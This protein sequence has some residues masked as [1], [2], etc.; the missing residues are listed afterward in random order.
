MCPNPKDILLNQIAL[1]LDTPLPSLNL[2]SSFIENGGDSLSSIQLQAAFRALGVHIGFESIFTSDTISHL[3][4]VTTP[5]LSLALA[6][7]DG[8]NCNHGKKRRL[9]A[10]TEHATKKRRIPTT[11]T[12][13]SV[14]PT[15]RYPMTEMQLA[16]VHSSQSHAG[17]NIIFY[18]ETHHPENVPAI[19]QAWKAVIKAE[20]IFRTTFELHQSGGYMV[21]NAEAD[22]IWEEIFV[23]DEKSFKIQLEDQDIED[24]FFGT[25]FRVITLSSDSHRTGRSTIIWRVHHAL[26]D[27]Y[28]SSL[29]LLK[30]RRVLH[31]EVITP[32]PSFGQFAADLNALQQSREEEGGLFWTKQEEEHPFRASRILLLAPTSTSTHTKDCLGQ[33]EMNVDIDTLTSQGHR[34]G[35]TSA[36]LF[37]AAWALTLA[38]YVDSD[39]VCFGAVLCG[40][41]LPIAGIEAIVGPTINTLPLSIKFDRDE[42]LTDYIHRVFAQMLALTEFQW[43]SPK[44]G[45]SRDFSS[46]LNVQLE[47]PSQDEFNIHPIEQPYSNIRSDVPL[48]VEVGND[49]T[50]RLSYHADIPSHS[51]ME[52]LMK[53]F[54]RALSMIWNTSFTVGICLGYLIDLE[55]RNVLQK[56]GNWLSGTTRIQSIQDDL[57]S[58]FNHAA[59]KNPDTMALQQGST[60]LTYRDLHI[61]SS[62]V[63]TRISQLISPG[64]VVCVHAD[65]SINWI[66]ATYAVLKAGAVYSPFDEELPAAMRDTNFGTTGAKLYLT[67]NT[68]AKSTRPKS[69]E[70]CLSVEELL[71]DT[72]IHFENDDSE[73]WTARP[74]AVAYLC[75][76]SG[77]TGEPKGVM[78]RHRG[79]VAF[80]SELEVRLFAQPGWKIA[81][82]MSPGFD[83]SIHEIFSALSY[84][85]TLI[86][87]DRLNPFS[88]LKHA[89]AAILTPSVA[90]ALDMEEF[91]NLK[92][93]YLVGEAVPQSVCDI[94]A[95]KKTLYNMYGPTEA[96]CGATIKQ[97][98]AGQP[99]TLGVPNI[100]TRIY[101][102]D[103]REEL[104]PSGVIGEIYLAG[105]QV[106]LGYIGRPD[107]T[108]KRFLPDSINPQFGECMYK[109]GD[110]GYWSENGELM[111]FG[112]SDRQ[113]KLRGFRIDLDDLEIR[114]LR[115]SV[116]TTAVA[117]TRKDDYLVAQVQP[118]DLNLTM[119][120]GKLLKV[121]PSYAMPRH[122]S[123]VESFP[124]TTIG[125][126]DYK[127]MAQETYKT[128]SE[129]ASPCAFPAE[130]ELKVALRDVL[131]LPENINI[132][133]DSNFIELGGTSLQQLFLSQRLTRSLKRHVPVRLILESPTLRDLARDL[134]SLDRVDE[135]AYATSLGDHGVS[136]I[137]REWWEKVQVDGNT[138]AF[139][140]NFACRLGDTIDQSRL[141]FAWNRILERHRILSCRYHVSEEHGL[142][143]GYAEQP[144]FIR[145]TWEIDIQE[146]INKP[147]DLHSSDLIRVTLSPIHMVIVISHIICD[148]TTLK[149]LLSEVADTYN[150]KLL[151]PIRKEYSQTQWSLPILPCQ[152]SF[153]SDYLADAPKPMFSVGNNNPRISWTGTSVVCEI[154]TAI[155]HRM[156]QCTAMQK[157]T[158]HQLSLAAVALAL[159]HK[160]AEC[161]ITIG[162]PYLN[163]N[164]EEDLGVVGLFL[165]PLPIRIR[166]PESKDHSL[167]E[168]VKHSSR[169]ALSRAVPWNQLLAHLNIVADFPN[170]PIL[171]AM[172]TFHEHGVQPTLPIPDVEPLY[173]WTQGS[174]FKIMAEFSARSMSKLL[175][176]LEY[177]TE[178]FTKDD[179]QSMQRMVIAALDGLTAG[180]MYDEIR[181][182]ISS[183]RSLLGVTAP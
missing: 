57:V 181:E 55:H 13:P 160:E 89:D 139:N 161:D 104:V 175:L 53:T 72:H 149:T 2:H 15:I 11:P 93:V 26:I 101:I 35:V 108:A 92:T 113:I 128:Y 41:A 29:V 52:S 154:P 111:F 65:R 138:S 44:H 58:L 166:Y 172:V 78:C 88:H 84:G 28:S 156:Q 21:E 91:P 165:E 14:N 63:S 33:V 19:K 106:S 158:M 94:W 164:S 140:V 67:G 36:T 66:I 147:F 141:I 74:E 127:K 112:R 5:K 131:D 118:A 40:R 68:M 77:S 134:A 121:I 174:K 150:G 80:Q 51:H 59:R 70:I 170:H 137:E 155:Y 122:I 64:D 125:K 8:K 61:K 103:N 37:Y 24:N 60:A 116:Q 6:A 129:A 120:R 178:C 123:A 99:V 81:Q 38:K 109:T 135:T 95:A 148:L 18:H 96:T 86:L 43:S 159:Q 115:A 162:A 144:P 142:S 79:L 100:S 27:G 124:V 45:F 42:R 132:D 179:V 183:T 75:F 119:Y 107:E 54:S 39:D 9:A 1:A 71:L 62:L 73:E 105:V 97:L 50:I 46:A 157:I 34:I 47:F 4:D 171:D 169:A 90:N 10:I 117:V 31:G 136:P 69:C 16:F 87:K 167:L 3:L 85:A 23:H 153:W 163:R 30:M 98:H 83:G 76:T 17:R 110:R 177:S 130:S 126:L 102:L 56:N 143:R 25:S 22:F 180:D 133:L 48:H 12:V 145:Q 146:E 20:P 49:G 82:F 32:G 173:T 152:S 114:M 168:A 7:G 182:K 176:R 151:E